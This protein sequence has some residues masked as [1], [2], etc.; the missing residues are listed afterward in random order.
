MKKL[1][2]MFGALAVAAISAPSMGAADSLLAGRNLDFLEERYRYTGNAPASGCIAP[3]TS[4]HDG[5]LVY[6]LNGN[7]SIVIEDDKNISLQM[8]FQ[9]NKGRRVCESARLHGTIPSIL[10]R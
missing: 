8:T 7:T 10:S 6:N 4:Q 9:N 3:P 2:N 5:A 1:S